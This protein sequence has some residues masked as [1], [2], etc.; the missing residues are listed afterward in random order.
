MP[1]C[2]YCHGVILFGGVKQDGLT[3]CNANCQAGGE[4]MSIASEVPPTL[5]AERLLAI[6]RGPCP[7]CGGPGPV[8]LQVSH[9]ITSL[10]VVT[11]WGTRIELACNRCGVK[12]KIWG[13]LHC[14]LMGWWGVWGLIMTPIQIMRNFFG[15][16]RKPDLSVTTPQL[17]QM[18]RVEI[19]QQVMAQ[20]PATPTR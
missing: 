2:A 17:E 7:K 10:L 18:I 8:D 19:A 15:A 3:F 16:F 9:V 4:V 12:K 13:I 5:V 1:S 11:S 14:M 6:R 20:G